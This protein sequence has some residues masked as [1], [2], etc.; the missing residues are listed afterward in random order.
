MS[1]D[2]CWKKDSCY[3]IETR[4]ANKGR[5][6]NNNSRKIKTGPRL[7][8]W[9]Q[10]LIKGNIFPC[11]SKQMYPFL[12][13][14]IN[15]KYFFSDNS[16]LRAIEAYILSLANKGSRWRLMKH[17]AAFAIISPLLSICGYP[18]CPWLICPKIGLGPV[19]L[20]PRENQDQL[21]CILRNAQLFLPFQQYVAAQIVLGIFS[22]KMCMVRAYW[23][24]PLWESGQ[25]MIQWNMRNYFS[26]STICDCSECPWHIF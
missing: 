26:L 4:K 10:A 22:K 18:N 7:K 11:W 13:L 15:W 3:R 2:L 24:N 23:R 6:W 17:S 20:T 19:D 25:T 1:R 14:K 12:L 9:V 8:N 5:W 16:I 21:W